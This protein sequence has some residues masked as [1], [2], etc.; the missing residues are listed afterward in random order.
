[1]SGLLFKLSYKLHIHLE[2]NDT[3]AQICWLGIHFLPKFWANLL[4]I[5][6][7]KLFAEKFFCSLGHARVQRL[8]AI[9]TT[10]WNKNNI[11][12][13][14]LTAFQCTELWN[15]PKSVWRVAQGEIQLPYFVTKVR[16]I[17]FLTYCFIIP[18]V[19][20]NSYTLSEGELCFGRHL[21]VFPW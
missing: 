3:Q 2:P 21:V 12:L 4:C 8:Q 18:V 7:V 13:K 15:Y 20:C 14:N 10:R 16:Q 1:M 9:S 5:P 19:G 17:T 6:L 11:Y